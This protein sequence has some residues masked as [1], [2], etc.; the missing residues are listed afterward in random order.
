MRDGEGWRGGGWKKED[1][2]G[3]KERKRER[4]REIYRFQ[5][6][7]VTEFLSTSIEH[8]AQRVG[9]YCRGTS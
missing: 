5:V 3:E 9:H 7:D 8:R 2:E 1:N 6:A 4:E